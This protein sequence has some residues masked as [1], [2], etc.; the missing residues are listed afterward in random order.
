MALNSMLLMHGRSPLTAAPSAKELIDAD[1]AA[2]F[3]TAG[4]LQRLC[5]RTL[6]YTDSPIKPKALSQ[7]IENARSVQAGGPVLRQQIEIP[8]RRH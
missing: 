8:A 7:Q 5:R 2:S 4:D 3:P 1:V 6:A